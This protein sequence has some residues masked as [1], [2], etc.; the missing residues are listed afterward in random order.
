[1]CTY[2]MNEKGKNLLK[3]KDEYSIENEIDRMGEKALRTIAVGVKTLK[4]DEPADDVNL[5]NE[6]TFVGLFGVIDPP[7]KE[8]KSA[9]KECAEAGIKTVM[10]TG[11]HEK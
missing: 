8:V 9:V 6:L 3:Q 1:R 5:E 10:I 2:T 7:R 4:K 11:D